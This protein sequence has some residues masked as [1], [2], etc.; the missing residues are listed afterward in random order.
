MLPDEYVRSVLSDLPFRYYV[1]EGRWLR[2]GRV[3][4]TDEELSALEAYARYG[5]DAI[6]EAM[7]KGTSIIGP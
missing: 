1:G 3:A 2:K 7:E 4:P 6:E 5:G